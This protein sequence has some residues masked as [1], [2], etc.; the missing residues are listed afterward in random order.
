[1]FPIFNVERKLSFPDLKSSF[2]VKH[3]E[4][5]FPDLLREKKVF[6]SDFPI[7]NDKRKLSFPDLRS[8]FPVKHREFPFPDL[9][10]ENKVF[11]SDSLIFNRKRKLSFPDLRSSFAVKYREFRIFRGKRRS[12][13]TKLRLFRSRSG[14]FIASCNK[15]GGQTRLTSR[16]ERKST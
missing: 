5:P 6:N 1:D 11:N 16:G 14:F 8:S 4:F 15:R 7:F 13:K 9:W 3:W 2:I 10:P 12:S